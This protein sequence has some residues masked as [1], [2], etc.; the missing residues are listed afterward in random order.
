ML[1]FQRYSDLV[2]LLYFK[3]EIVN[4]ENFENMFEETIE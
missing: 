2:D 1:K 3:S 4:I